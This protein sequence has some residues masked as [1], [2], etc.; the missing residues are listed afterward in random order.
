M[1]AAW[2][3]VARSGAVRPTE[4][5]NARGLSQAL[6]APLGAAPDFLEG[7]QVPL[8]GDL[9]DGA[10]VVRS[11]HVC[12]PIEPAVWSAE[13]FA[14]RCRAGG[15][16]VEVVEHCLSPE[17]LPRYG[18]RKLKNVSITGDSPLI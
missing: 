8:R 12:R 1:P 10:P 7:R 3:A 17:A 14:D 5:L 13:Q 18:W 16:D 6:L 2:R 9:E 11:S 15:R 4:I